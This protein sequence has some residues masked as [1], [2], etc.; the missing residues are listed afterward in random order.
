MGVATTTPSSCLVA[1]FYLTSRTMG[2]ATS[3]AS[4][5]LV[6]TLYLKMLPFPV[7]VDGGVALRLLTPS[8]FPLLLL[9][10][11]SLFRRY[12]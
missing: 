2:S 5:L 9:G 10:R 6:T 3:I 7:C 8:L 12:R 1:I 4:S 11:H